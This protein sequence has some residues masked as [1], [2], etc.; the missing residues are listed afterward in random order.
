MK[1]MTTFKSSLYY[2]EFRTI[3]IQTATRAGYHQQ[4]QLNLT[5]ELYAAA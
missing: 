2:P 1:E 5:V 4:Q 3:Q